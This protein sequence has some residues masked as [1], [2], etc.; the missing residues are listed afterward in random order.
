VSRCH[1]ASLS[2]LFEIAF[3]RL[4][5]DQLKTAHGSIPGRCMD[6]VR[7]QAARRTRKE[8]THRQNQASGR[9]LIQIRSRFFVE[10]TLNRSDQLK[11]AHAAARPHEGQSR[12]ETRAR[13][14]S[15]FLSLTRRTRSFTASG[16]GRPSR[17]ISDCAPDPRRANARTRIGAT[18]KLRLPVRSGFLLAQLSEGRSG[19]VR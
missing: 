4:G 9:V 16:P 3:S 15:I 2:F 19:Q 12:W 14:S 17:S 8:P 13:A 18:G 11:T 6:V 10:S 7:S 5:S 1:C